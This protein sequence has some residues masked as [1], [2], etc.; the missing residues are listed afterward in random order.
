MEVQHTKLYLDLAKE[1]EEQQVVIIRQGEK[2]A[3]VIEAHIYDHGEEA[4][5]SDV[6]PY[7]TM[8][9]PKGA[10]LED[11][12]TQVSGN[13]VTY[14]V[15]PQAAQEVGTCSV[16]YF[17]FM[18][19]ET[20]TATTHATTQAFAI[21]ILPNAQTDGDGIAEA[22][23]SR[24]E[25]MLQWC[26]DTF[27]EN[28]EVRD[29]KVD[30]AVADAEA[31]TDRANDAAKAVEDAVSGTLE[32]LFGAYI[33]QKIIPITNQELDTWWGGVTPEPGDDEYVAMTQSQIDAMFD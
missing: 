1:P 19:G 33:D 31:A 15:I 3:T 17:A 8:R 32:P 2:K 11:K 28:E 9:H 20:V 12:C 23:A 21:V 13:V 14:E 25:E 24:I 7:F 26:H 22:Y 27:L 18:D 16:A 6:T 30:A 5:L 29:E 10:L 4:D